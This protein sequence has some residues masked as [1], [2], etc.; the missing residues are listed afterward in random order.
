MDDDEELDNDEEFFP[1]PS[2]DEIMASNDQ[3][4]DE[5]ITQVQLLHIQQNHEPDSRSNGEG[6]RPC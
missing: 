3:S 4:V 5:T 6:M 1:A 2:Q